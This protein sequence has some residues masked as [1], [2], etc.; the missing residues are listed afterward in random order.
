[1]SIIYTFSSPIISPS[2]ISIRTK[3]ILL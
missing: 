1:L 3:L 2:G